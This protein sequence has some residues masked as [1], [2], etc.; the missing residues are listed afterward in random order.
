MARK[1]QLTKTM[2]GKFLR[3]SAFNPK[4][5][6][7]LK[8]VIENHSEDPNYLEDRAREM[9]ADA[10]LA[11]KTGQLPAYHEKMQK[12]ITLAAVARGVRTLLS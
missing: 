2:I 7:P 10:Q 5:L 9:I 1:K 3:E 8:V 6:G 12:A 11:A 4:D